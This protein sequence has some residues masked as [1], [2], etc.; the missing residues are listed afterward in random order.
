MRISALAYLAV[1]VVLGV[2]PLLW[3]FGG[4]VWES[5]GFT[6]R[7]YGILIE[8]NTFRH[9]LNTV[10]LGSLTSLGTLFLGIPMSYIL[11]RTTMRLKHHLLVL[12][13]VPIFLP[14]YILAVAWRLLLACNGLAEQWLGIGDPTSKFLDSIWGCAFI[15]TTAYLPVTI[16]F[17]SNAFRYINPSVEEAARL[18]GSEVQVMRHV[19][20]PGIRHAILSSALIVFLLAISEFGVPMIL[21][22]QVFT[23]EIF[24]QFAAFYNEK[25]AVALSL[26][27]LLFALVLILWERKLIAQM[28]FVS[29]DDISALQAKHRGL[30]LWSGPA[31]IVCCLIVLVSAGLPLAVIASQASADAFTQA[32]RIGEAPMGV[33]LTT[34]II[35]ATV[36]SVVGLG[37]GYAV[38]RAHAH[39]IDLVTMLLFAAPAT[40]IGIGLIKFWNAPLFSG[41]VYNTPVVIIIGFFVRFLILTERIF[42]SALAQIPISFEQSARIEGASAFQLARYV[43]MPLLRPAFVT[44]WIL[45]FIFCFGELTTTIIVYPAGGATLPISLYTIMANS[46]ETLTASMSLL[47]VLPILFAVGV[48]FLFAQRMRLLTV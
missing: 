29:E 47:L 31:L 12:S 34:A 19:T 22:V 24:T 23:T 8:G 7:Q 9:L 1:I 2:L 4:S 13:L 30:K 26:P 41:I 46:P 17:L 45:A 6:L 15:L 3:M 44:A 10:A 40:I 21:G 36:L 42:A 38:E 48:F 35:G 14:P 11:T 25:A 32:I 20:L 37:T 28:A 18:D 5:D 16:L 33:S 27:L 43:I 39:A